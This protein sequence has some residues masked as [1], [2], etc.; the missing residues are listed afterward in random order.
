MDRIFRSLSE[1]LTFWL[2]LS[3][4][5]CGAAD[6]SLCEGCRLALA[7]R[8]H[9]RTIGPGVIVTAALAFDGVAARTVRALKEEG[10]TSL[11]RALGPALRAAVC[12]ATDAHGGLPSVRVTAVPSSRSAF[13][14]RGYRPV[15][16]LLRA[17]GVRAERLLRVARTP[18][19]QRG[20]GRVERRANVAGAL[21][22]RPL[23]G[24]VVV[25]VDDVVTTGATLVEADRALRA[26][27]ADE[28]VVVALAHTPRRDGSA[29]EPQGNPR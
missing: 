13:R 1:A 14:R 3:C 9:R 19:D 12:A 25:V 27:G 16:L 22:A 8:V 11:A 5:G 4:A 6:V 18:R 20:L 15:D 26:A 2:P 7:P 10:R 21:A 29:G 24:G 28:V 17:G 23:S